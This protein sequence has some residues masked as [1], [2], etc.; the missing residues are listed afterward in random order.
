MGN[1]FKKRG[2]KDWVWLGCPCEQVRRR[3]GVTRSLNRGPLAHVH[4]ERRQLM[5]GWGGRQGPDLPA[6]LRSLDSVLELWATG[7]GLGRKKGTG[8]LMF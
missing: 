1:F 6:V 5:G 3:V 8:N 4:I 2:R 7:K